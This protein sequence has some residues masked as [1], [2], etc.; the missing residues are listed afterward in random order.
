MQIPAQMEHVLRQEPTVLPVAKRCAAARDV[1][2]LGRGSQFPVALEGAL[3]LKEISY[4]HAEGYAAGEMKHGPIALID[5]NLPVVVLAAKEPSYEK[6]LGNVEE[7]RARGGQ[8]IAVVA[9]GDTHAA[10]LATVALVVPAE[11]AA[12]R[13]A[14]HHPAAP[15]PR[16]PRG[17]PEGDRRGPAAEPGQ[18]RHRRVNLRLFVALEPPDPVRRRLAAAQAELRRS[19]G[20]H[21][22][23][24]RWVAP[25]PAAPDAPVPG[26]GSGGAARGDPRCRGG[27][28][29]RVAPAPPR[30]ARGRRLSLGAAAPG[31]LGRRGRGPG[32]APGAGPRAGARARA[33]R[34]PGRRAGLHA[35]FHLRSIPRRTGSRRPG[36]RHRRRGGRGADP[37]AGRRGGPL[38][39][40]PRTRAGPATSRS[41]G[42]RSATRATRRAET[43]SRFPCLCTDVQYSSVQV[44][45][46]TPLL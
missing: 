44:R 8:V 39:V 43:G 14:A 17:R 25:G 19:A 32:R 26:R 21:A 10:S 4:I 23:E 36:R 5:E 41:C 3:K 30:G 38:P 15:V 40:P 11:P 45:C 6:T 12:A 1:L 24:V 35:A 37:L 42:P 29:G 28:G 13:P 9:E 31:D 34:L 16:L 22:E 46:R 7:V 33:A 20:R 18:E 27:R 2:F